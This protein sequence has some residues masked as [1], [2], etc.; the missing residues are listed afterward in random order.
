MILDE[1][2][3]FLVFWQKN[4]E[5]R[6]KKSYKIFSGLPYGL[7]FAL[8]ILINYIMGRFWYKRA[9]AVGMS[10]SSTLILVIAI[11]I[12]SSFIAFFYK[13]FQW[14]QYEQRF[15]ELNHKLQKKD[16]E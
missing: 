7:L 14:E 2:R 9:D 1:E 6:K 8:P 15:Q 4:R 5:L 13:Q 12:I 3:K 10:Q 16:E 11:I